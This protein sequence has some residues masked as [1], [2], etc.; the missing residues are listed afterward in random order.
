MEGFTSVQS[1]CGAC[2]GLRESGEFAAPVSFPPL[3]L[4]TEEAAVRKPILENWPTFES[5]SAR[6]NGHDCAAR[7]SALR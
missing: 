5:S 2:H 6:G 4:S 1:E 3:L 7:I